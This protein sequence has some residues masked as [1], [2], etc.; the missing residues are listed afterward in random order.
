MRGNC[1]TEDEPG[2]AS[3]D[4]LVQPEESL[5]PLRG[6]S[7]GAL[8]RRAERDRAP[9]GIALLQD[10]PVRRT[11]LRRG[12]SA[13]A[14]S[15]PAARGMT[16]EQI[17]LALSALGAVLVG[18]ILTVEGVTVRQGHLHFRNIRWRLAWWCAW[19]SFF[20]GIAGAVFFCGSK[21]S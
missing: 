1:T 19:F 18:V 2:T 17:A 16:C 9:A 13:R 11:C 21:V 5:R 4:M 14:Y 10:G 8:T 12:R 20:L 3:Y 6:R 7:P 15:T